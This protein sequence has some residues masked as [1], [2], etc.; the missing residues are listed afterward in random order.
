M[1][2]ALAYFDSLD[3]NMSMNIIDI[4]INKLY[5]YKKYVWQAIGFY[6]NPQGETIVEGKKVGI[7]GDRTDRR[8]KALG[9]IQTL[10]PC[11]LTEWDGEYPER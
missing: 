9:S 3:Y 10:H 4:E 5:A 1:I 8:M 6:W 11:Y 2:L 7:L